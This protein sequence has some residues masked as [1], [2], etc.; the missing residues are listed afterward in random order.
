MYRQ[1][2]RLARLTSVVSPI[3]CAERIG[4]GHFRGVA[5]VVMKLFQ[6]VQADRAYFGEKD[7]QQLAIIRRL[8]ADFNVPTTIVRRAD[9]ARTR[10]PGAELAEPA[11]VARRAAAGSALLRGAARGRRQI[12]SGSRDADAILRTAPRRSCRP[13]P[14][15]GSSTWRSWIRTTCSLCRP[16]DGPVL[17]GGCAL[18][19]LDAAHRQR[20]VRSPCERLRKRVMKLR[21]ICKSKIHHAVVTGGRPALHRQHRHRS[22]A[23]GADRHRAGRAG[24]GLERQQRAAD[25]DLRDRNAGRVGTDC[26]ERRGRQALPSGRHGHHRRVLPD[27]RGRRRRR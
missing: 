3:T 4:P 25:R 18:G 7:A 23:D 27:G 10:W 2:P 26:R 20:A 24:V 22:R 1:P 21:T 15:C 11:P 6:I 13:I 16:I 9:G 5:T 8:V 14:G 17:R 19:R 12:A